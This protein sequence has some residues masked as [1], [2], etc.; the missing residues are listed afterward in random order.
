MHLGIYQPKSDAPKTE[1]PNTKKSDKDKIENPNLEINHKK[2]SH[3]A[4]SHEHAVTPLEERQ[5]KPNSQIV[6]S[7]EEIKRLK[8]MVKQRQVMVIFLMLKIS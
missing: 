2:D 7:P 8:Q 1:E 3:K 5:G 6:Y 4:D